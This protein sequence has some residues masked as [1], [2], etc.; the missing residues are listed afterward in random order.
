MPWLAPKGYVNTHRAIFEQKNLNLDLRWL[1]DY[2]INTLITSSKKN[3]AILGN[4]RFFFL[5]KSQF[6]NLHGLTEFL[7]TGW[8]TFDVF[9][10]LKI[11]LIKIKG[12]LIIRYIFRPFFTIF[13]CFHIRH[14]ITIYTFI[15]RNYYRT[16]ICKFDNYHHRTRFFSKRRSN[17]LNQTEIKQANRA[18][19]R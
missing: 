13:L 2:L 5:N 8:W 1:R 14:I 16:I 3:D 7:T 18:S 4:T 19:T 17:T 12:K 6:F 9:V 15:T 10:S 11:L